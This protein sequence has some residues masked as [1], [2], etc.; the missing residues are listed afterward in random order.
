MSGQKQP[1]NPQNLRYGSL[2]KVCDKHP[3]DHKLPLNDSKKNESGLTQSFRLHI[4]IRKSV[5]EGS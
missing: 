3:A 2:P 1:A 4:L 5:R